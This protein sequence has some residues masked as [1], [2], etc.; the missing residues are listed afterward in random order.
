MRYP[1]FKLPAVVG[2]VLLLVWP[3]VSRAAEA[4]FVGKV[5]AVQ[6]G[7]RFTISGNGA[8]RAY[9]LEEIVSPE[10][11]QPFGQQARDFSRSLL[12][13][14]PV[15]VRANNLTPSKS[16]QARLYLNGADVRE[17]LLTRGLARCSLRAQPDLLALQKRAENKKLGLWSVDQRPAWVQQQRLAKTQLPAKT[18]S[19][20]EGKPALLLTDNKQVAA[21]YD[22]PK[23]LVSG[24][25]IRSA[26]SAESIA[27]PSQYDDYLNAVVVIT[28]GNSLGSGFFINNSGKILTNHHVIAQGKV[29]V[30]LR[31]GQEFAGRVVDYDKGFDL[32]LVEI[33]Y[34]N[35]TKLNL[36]L[37]ADAAVGAEVMAI[38]SPQGLSWS[39]SR[40]IVSAIRQDPGYTVLQTDAAINP[41]NSG[42]PLISLA[43]GTVVGVNAFGLRKSISEGLNFAVAVNE[44]K[45]FLAN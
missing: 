37:L 35:R 1:H 22:G 3:A 43:T 25:P 8:T 20:G 15:Y 18:D 28:S 2:L 27:I 5:V 7:S 17:E 12:L 42:G 16:W 26:V 10:L 4:A 33:P 29:M 11:R 40:G 34:Q 14:K 44:I 19:A 9:T 6:S 23:K 21:N 31:D 45:R 24:K 41:G 39:V 36:G 13:G 30:K 32:A 38:G